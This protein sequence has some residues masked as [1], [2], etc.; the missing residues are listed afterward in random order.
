MISAMLAPEALIQ[1]FLGT[2]NPS[3]RRQLA[4]LLDP[5]TDVRGVTSTPIREELQG[6]GELT[7]PQVPNPANPKYSKYVIDL[8]LTAR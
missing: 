8:S 7:A 5:E 4:A 3:L 6:L 1:A 2:V